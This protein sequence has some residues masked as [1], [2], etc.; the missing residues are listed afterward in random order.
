MANYESRRVGDHEFSFPHFPMRVQKVEYTYADLDASDDLKIPVE[1]GQVVLA[2]AHEVVTAFS[3]GTPALDIGDGTDV[4]FW[5]VNTELDL[6]TEGDFFISFAS[7]QP[8]S[9]GAKFNAAGNVQLSHAA[10]L[11]AGA[12]IVYLLIIDPR[13]NWRTAGEI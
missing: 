6:S 5:I 2:V 4:D 9:S 11:S 8:G 10:S 13:T 3:G 1:A 7:A 12:G